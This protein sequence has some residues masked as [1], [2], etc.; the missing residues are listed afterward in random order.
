MEPT[1]QPLE[2][3][4]TP[5]AEVRPAETKPSG[6]RRAVLTAAISGLLLVAGGVAVVSAAS[7]EPSASPS[8]A[9]PSDGT[10]APSDGTDDPA[11]PHGR[12]GR[13]PGQ[14]RRHRRHR[15][16]R[17]LRRVLDHAEH[18]PP[19]RS[20]RRR[21]DLEP[22]GPSRRAAGLILQ[23]RDASSLERGRESLVVGGFVVALGGDPD[24]DPRRDAFALR[25]AGPATARSGPGS[26]PRPPGSSPRAVG[27][28]LVRHARAAAGPPSNRASRP[29]PAARCRARPRRCP[30]PRAPARG[31]RP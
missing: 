21:R 19:A 7:P 29:A 5:S 6:V 2:P 28:R 14:G 13:L 12:Q 22:G 25:G 30:D 10:T 24:E 8:T 31:S 26:G 3:A 1:F 16:H 4:P 20:R 9:A 27:R 17:R 11:H 18:R 23:A 15:R